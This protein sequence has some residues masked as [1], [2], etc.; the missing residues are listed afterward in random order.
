MSKITV[1][2]RD[3]E[4][5][6]LPAVCLCCGASPAR[7]SDVSLP[8]TPTGRRLFV[9]PKDHH[10]IALFSHAAA[11]FAPLAPLAILRNILVTRRLAI[12]LPLCEVHHR[13]ATVQHPR[14][15]VA[16]L[17]LGLLGIGFS[18]L[19]VVA[20]TRAVRAGINPTE[21]FGDYWVYF[22]VAFFCLMTGLFI[23]ARLH[24]GF[25]YVASLSDEEIVL[26]GVSAQAAEQVADL[27][28][29]RSQA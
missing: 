5:G 9:T 28:R 8:Y 10:E 24:D 3:L 21:E 1:A 25:L 14:L 19:T 13:A 18:L 20:F 7:R 11:F 12:Q 22:G 23:R 27:Q 6:S 4:L 17:L 16:A 26:G 29:S 2:R 15:R